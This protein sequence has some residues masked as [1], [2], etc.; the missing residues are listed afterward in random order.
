M[1]AEKNG[2]T[3]Q[4]VGPVSYMTYVKPFM[5]PLTISGIKADD[6]RMVYPGNGKGRL[7][8]TEINGR[9]Y[10]VYGGKL[11][12]Q[13]AMR[14]FD[15]TSFPMALLGVKSIAQP[16]YGKQLCDAVNACKCDLEQVSSADLAQ[17]FKDD[18]IPYG[19]YVLFSAGHVLLYNS[20]INTLFEFTYGGFKATPAGMREL[21]APQDLWWM[22]RIDESYRPRFA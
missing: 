13:D 16:G 9:Y 3:L 14:G 7:L 20:D 11:E 5:G 12:T 17:R 19:L 4:K 22:R 18:V 2:A 1:V 6:P 10:F 15:C 21:K 8:S